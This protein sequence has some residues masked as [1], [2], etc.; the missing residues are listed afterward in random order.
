[1]YISLKNIEVI[2]EKKCLKIESLNI[3]TLQQTQLRTTLHVQQYLHQGFSLG[4]TFT[5]KILMHF[6]ISLFLQYSIF[7]SHLCVFGVLLF[8]CDMFWY[9]L[10]QSQTP[11]RLKI[12]INIEILFYLYFGERNTQPTDQILGFC[13]HK[14]VGE[15]RFFFFQ[16]RKFYYEK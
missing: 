14:F 3:F 7:N 12:D 4:T 8:D 9:K 5:F 10:F 1:M 11:F 6:D 15:T 16:I 2:S 13:L